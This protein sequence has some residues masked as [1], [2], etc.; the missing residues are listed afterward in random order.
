METEGEK[1]N[2]AGRYYYELANIQAQKN[3]AIINNDIWHWYTCLEACYYFMSFK[4]YEYPKKKEAKPI[5]EIIE[6][7]LKFI[8]NCFS[9]MNDSNKKRMENLI[10]QK[11]QTTDKN[12]FKV[13]NYFRMIFPKV[14]NMDGIAMVRQK[15]GLGCEK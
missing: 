8:E 2:Y 5:H 14:E 6:A 4:A 1:I 11:L 12:I 13:L 7:D 9:G 3:Q 15:L 10:K